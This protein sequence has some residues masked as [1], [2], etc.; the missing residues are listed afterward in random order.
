MYFDKQYIYLHNIYIYIDKYIFIN[1]IYINN[2]II[3]KD[4]TI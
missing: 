2:I 3:N 1:I 4:L